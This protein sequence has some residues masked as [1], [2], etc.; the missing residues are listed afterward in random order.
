MSDLKPEDFK[1]IEEAAAVIRK[2]YDAEHFRHTVGAAVRCS[3]GKVYAG[4]NVY[5]LH[6]ACAEFIA[7]GAA[8]S[9]GERRFECI[10]A[11]GG[12]H[13][14]QIYPPCGNCRQ[15]LSTYMPNGQVIV[16]NSGRIRKVAV[17]DLLPFAYS[18][19][20]D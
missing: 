14:D 8:V 18:L 11:I 12:E 1:L 16:E 19:P 7:I 2:N 6:G 20:E 5:S 13:S 10:V 9:D 15:M 3:S 17:S 4:V